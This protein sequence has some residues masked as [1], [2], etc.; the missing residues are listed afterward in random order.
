MKNPPG[1]ID[2]CHARIH[3]DQI[4]CDGSPF[5]ERKEKEKRAIEHLKT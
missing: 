2:E 1:L 4:I 3:G 5:G